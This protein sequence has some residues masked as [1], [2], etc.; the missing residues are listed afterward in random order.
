MIVYRITHRATGK[1]YIGSSARALPPSVALVVRWA[2]HV[3]GSINV[4]KMPLHKAIAEHGPEAFAYVVLYEAV[5][6]RE[7]LAVE[8]GAIARYGTLHPHGYNHSCGSMLRAIWQKNLGRANSSASIAKRAAKLRGQTRTLEQRAL[9]GRNRCGKGL[10]N[11]ASAKLS[12]GEVSEI[13]LRLKAGQPPSLL[14]IEYGVRPSTIYRI[15]SGKRWPEVAPSL[16]TP[17][18]GSACHS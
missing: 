2:E 7:M 3:I 11:K 10:L 17:A 13:K 1:S 15:R 8:R 14:A 4:G 6:K 12:L 18:A 9:M 16:V 5:D